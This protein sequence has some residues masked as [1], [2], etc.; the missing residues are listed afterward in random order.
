LLLRC[1]GKRQGC[2]KVRVG[3]VGYAEFTPSLGR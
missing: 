1:Y 2:A 3:T